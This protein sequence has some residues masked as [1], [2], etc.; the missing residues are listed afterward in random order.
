MSGA[1]LPGSV[2]HVKHEGWATAASEMGVELAPGA[3]SRLDR[4]ERF[5]V[6]RAS[7]E[8][9]VAAGDAPRIRDRHI[10]DCLR[11]A[12]LILSHDRRAYDLGSGAGLPGV[13]IAIACPEL[14]VVLV[15]GRRHRS[16]FLREVVGE[17]E[18]AN[19]TVH[20]GKAGAL[21]DRVADRADVCL[22]RAFAPAKRGWA[23][24]E[25]L[26]V[27]EGRLVYWAGRRADL[28]AELPRDASWEVVEPPSDT[29]SGPLAVIR[30]KV[31]A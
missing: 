16:D 6:E 15:E 2:F 29:G 20:A 27:P 31:V 21:T 3:E 11:A 19:A 22:S 13:V 5:L 9:M 18:L 1:R 10:L 30:R 26:L 23:V 8:G 28:S 17:L 12:P 24:A 25:R 14:H 4:Y 7:R